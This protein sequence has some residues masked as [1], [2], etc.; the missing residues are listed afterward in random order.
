MMK[1][2]IELVNTMTERNRHL[3]LAGMLNYESVSSYYLPY[4]VKEISDEG[5]ADCKLPILLL[6]SNDGSVRRR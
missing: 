5:F 6:M 3:C 4:M 1:E 2:K